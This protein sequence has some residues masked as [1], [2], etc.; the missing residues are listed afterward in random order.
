MRGGHSGDRCAGSM[1]VPD[2]MMATI[3]A[4]PPHCFRVMFLSRCV[5]A[6]LVCLCVCRD[7][8]ESGASGGWGRSPGFCVSNIDVFQ[9]GQFGLQGNTQTNGN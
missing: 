1:S 9:V 7:M 3:E 4:T 8:Y 2:L 5:C 6:H